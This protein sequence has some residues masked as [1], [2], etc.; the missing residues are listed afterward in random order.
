MNGIAD[1]KLVNY[2]GTPERT[3]DPKVKH[4]QEMQLQIIKKKIT[5][6][7]AHSK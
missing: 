1:T 6:P 3:F 5:T 2:R 7:T 4:N